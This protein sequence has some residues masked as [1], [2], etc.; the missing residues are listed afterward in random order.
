VEYSVQLSEEILEECAHI[1]RTKGKVV[2]DFTLEIKDKSG[3][4]C[5][6]VRCET[7]IRDLNFTFPSRNRNIEPS[8]IN[9][10][11]QLPKNKKHE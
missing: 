10:F 3:D 2:K 8:E 4:L 11:V 6:T 5:A 7:Y 1:I 9:I